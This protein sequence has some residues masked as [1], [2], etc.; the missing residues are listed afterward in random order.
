V[1]KLVV[2]PTSSAKRE[3]PLPRSLLSIGRDPSNDLVLPDAMVSRRHAVIEFRGSQYYI[4]DCNSSNGS[5][6][7]GD[8]I[9]ER[10]L[11][12]GDLVAIGTARLLF[13]EDVEV[14]ELGAKVVQ[15]PSSPRLNCPSCGSDHR[16]GDL[17][18]RQ[19]G[20]QLAQNVPPK[21]VCTSCGTVVPLPA[22][23]CNAC[24]A[25]LTPEE[26]SPDS[27]RP[28]PIPPEVDVERGEPKASTPEPEHLTDLPLRPPDAS[29]PG[30]SPRAQRVAAVEHAIAPAGA[31]EVAPPPAEAPNP[32]PP[33]RPQRIE[34]R[35]REFA[36]K[37][38][39]IRVSEPAGRLARLGA[40]LLDS[41]LVSLA[42]LALAA[43][44]VYYWLSHRWPPSS[45]EPLFVP[46]LLSMAVFCLGLLLGA[47][48]YVYFWGVKG[49][50]PGKQALG[51]AVEGIDGRFPIGFA[52][53]AARLFGYIVSGALLGI[54]F[55]LIAFGKPALHDRIAGTRVVRRGGA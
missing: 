36:E 21:A 5:L 53:A 49:A 6:V 3:I 41:A 33:P 35:P 12:D 4:R 17:F 7:N 43:P 31:K 2:N 20:A 48:Y 14:E 15:H 30:E 23:F 26:S 55:L 38:Q 45:E 9:S 16:K 19:C 8:K 34:P 44:V 54:G 50:T 40:S 42:Q 25:V 37:P 32:W 27:T 39:R 51:I 11:R 52:K 46:I 22:K 1:A 28:R 47:G 10:N 18:C 24:G 13:R 29:R